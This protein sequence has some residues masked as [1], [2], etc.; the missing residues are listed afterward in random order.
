MVMGGEPL[1]PNNRG[2]SISASSNGGIRSR[3]ISIFRRNEM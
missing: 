1:D 2:M 3:R